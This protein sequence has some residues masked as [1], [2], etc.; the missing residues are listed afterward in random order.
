M[1]NGISLSSK[2]LSS[3]KMLF[4]TKGSHCSGDQ[5]PTEGYPQ[6]KLPMNESDGD[7]GKELRK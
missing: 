3:W 4:K 6:F 2:M 7:E 1:L 5:S